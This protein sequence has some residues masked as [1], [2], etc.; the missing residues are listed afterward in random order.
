MT[1]SWNN[2]VPNAGA[3]AATTPVTTTAAVT[4][5]VMTT[6]TPNNPQVV[7]IECT[8]GN[9]QR[10]Q[11]DIDVFA[12]L[13]L[14][15]YGVQRADVSMG[16]Y[17]QLVDVNRGCGASTWQGCSGFIRMRNGVLQL[18]VG[19]WHVVLEVDVHWT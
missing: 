11:C 15:N 14:A 8:V 12:D 6:T 7:R 5:T 3:T 10:K 18:E 17:K 4:T 9:N 1:I 2:S 16:S 13:N 19:S